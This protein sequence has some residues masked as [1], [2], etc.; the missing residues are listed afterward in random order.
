MTRIHGLLALLACH[1]G[2]VQS[3]IFT[4]LALGGALFAASSSLQA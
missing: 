4:T 2:L 1:A 3:L